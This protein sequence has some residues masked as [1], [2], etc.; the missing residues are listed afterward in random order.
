MNNIGWCDSTLNFVTGCTPVSTGCDNCYANR[1]STRRMGEWSKREFSEVMFH[2]D[3]LTN[4]K[5]SKTPKR[6]FANS[7]WD[8]GHKLIEREWLTQILATV[9][10]HPQHTFIFLT[11]RPENLIRSDWEGLENVVIGVSVEN[12]DYLGRLHYFKDW[13][14]KRMVSFEPLLSNIDLPIGLLKSSVDWVIIGVES[15]R[16]RRYCEYQWINGIVE[17]ADADGVPVYVKA[18]PD[19]Y[20]FKESE[21]AYLQTRKSFAN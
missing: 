13:K 18:I 11:K 9:A 6:V 20:S 3:R 7:M 8:V 2:P 14:V 15:G 19:N 4:V 16:G 12:S 10:K 5:L 1:L 17:A 21:F